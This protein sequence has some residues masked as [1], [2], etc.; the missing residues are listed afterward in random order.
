M[1]QTGTPFVSGQHGVATQYFEMRGRIRIDTNWVEEQSL[2]LRNGINVSVVWRQRG[3]GR[4]EVVPR[5]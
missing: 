2:L 3:S 4:T 1:Q 5:S